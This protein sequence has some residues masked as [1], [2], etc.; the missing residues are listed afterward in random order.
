MRA[1]QLVLYPA[2]RTFVSGLLFGSAYA[3]TGVSARG[4]LAAHQSA[5]SLHYMPNKH[6]I[7]QEINR[8]RKHLDTS[9]DE[10]EGNCK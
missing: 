7:D 9:G 4:H 8:V 1:P 3:D 10:R 2:R 5:C 6:S